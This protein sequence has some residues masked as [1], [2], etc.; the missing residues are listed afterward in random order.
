MR[1]VYAG[2]DYRYSVGDK[3]LHWENGSRIIFGGYKD[4]SDIDKYLGI[5][6]DLIVIEECTQLDF[7]KFQRIDGSLRTSRTD[8]WRTVMYLTCNPEGVGLQWA[9]RLFVQPWKN[10]EE[11][12]RHRFI[13]STYKDNK[14]TDPDYVTYLEDLEGPLGKAWREGDFDVFEGHAFPNWMRDRH[15]I[16]PFPI[17]SYWKVW[18]GIDDGYA[19]PFCTLWLTKDPQSRRTYVIRE[20]YERL[21]VNSAQAQLILDYTDRDWRVL[22]YKADPSMFNRSHRRRAQSA[23]DIFLEYGIRLVKAENS[24][25]PGKRLIDNL[26]ADGPDGQPRIQ[27]FEGECDNLIDQMSHLQFDP[28]NPE[29]VDTTMED[30]AYDALRYALSEKVTVDRT[31][32]GIYTA[33]AL[34]GIRSI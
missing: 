34:E 30:H 5:E 28:H 18:L 21:L 23:A 10:G 17:P 27:F 26:L 11:S 20:A 32:M 3:T 9:K 25:I 1:K 33:R 7:D 24:R 12:M 31:S 4:P 14:F 29:D 16:K 19:E 22:K 13:F 6:Y 8:G 15:V 2:M